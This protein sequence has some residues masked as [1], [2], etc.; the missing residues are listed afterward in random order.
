[1]K[2]YVVKEASGNVVGVVAEGSPILAAPDGEKKGLARAKEIA[3]DNGEC[4]EVLCMEIPI[5]AESIR[6]LL[7]GYGGYAR[8]CEQV[9]LVPA[10]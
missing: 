3:D 4:S 8:D 7:S 5:A 1:M 9:Y 2:F 6:L 10:S